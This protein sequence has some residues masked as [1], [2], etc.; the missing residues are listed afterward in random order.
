M[1]KCWCSLF[2]LDP[3]SFFRSLLYCSS[4]ISLLCCSSSSRRCSC[5]ALVRLMS[6]SNSLRNTPFSSLI[7]RVCSSRHCLASFK[8]NALSGLL[9]S[10]SEKIS[11]IFGFVNFWARFRLLMVYNWG[12]NLRRLLGHFLY[13]C[14]R[15]GLI[16]SFLPQELW[17]QF[18]D[19]LWMFSSH[20]V[21]FLLQSSNLC[22][23]ISL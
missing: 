14:I 6:C 19:C 4:R 21:Y 10:E 3:L 13:F 5:R 23:L 12:T 2:C 18:L 7:L 9:A 20:C 22:L 17:F 8:K 15:L 1:P 16:S 11:Q